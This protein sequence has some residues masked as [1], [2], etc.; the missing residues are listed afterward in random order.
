MIRK[1]WD[2]IAAEEARDAGLAERK[3]SLSK[4]SG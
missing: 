4:V 1:L 3:V 2:R